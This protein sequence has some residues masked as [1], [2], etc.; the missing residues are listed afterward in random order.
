MK[1]IEAAAEKYADNPDDW[2]LPNPSPQWNNSYHSFLAGA[3]YE[4]ERAKG[5]VEN[6]EKV[7]FALQCMIIN[8]NG[9]C[10]GLTDQQVFDGAC[11]ARDS[12]KDALEKWKA[13]L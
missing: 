2:A 8:K 6:A 5:L 3:A 10:P 12:F 13:E 1:N 9:P 11:E 7:L 4:R